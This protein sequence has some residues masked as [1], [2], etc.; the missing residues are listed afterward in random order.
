MRA[1]IPVLT[2]FPSFV[3]AGQSPIPQP[4]SASEV[5]RSNEIPAL[6]TIR[7]SGAQ[8]TDLGTVHGMRTVFARAGQRFQVFYVTAD[9]EAVIGGVMWNGAGDNI[10]REQVEA[11]DDVI[12]TVDAISTNQSTK[13]PYNQPWVKA[14]EA[15]TY[16]L[17]GNTGA[18]RL[19]MFFDPQCSFSIRAM[20]Q[21][22]PYVDQGRVQL[23]LVPVSILDHEDG[24]LSTKAALSLLSQPADQ[25]AA[26]WSAGRVDAP[27][28]DASTKLSRNMQAA[29]QI[30]LR[31]TPTF[32][33]R[34]AD[35]SEGRL[36]GVP[37]DF[38]TL[39]ARVGS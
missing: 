35:G 29:E 17:I 36:D 5:Q 16:G 21:L 25:M 26:S 19:W 13:Q 18:P 11:I 9:G 2:L 38:G 12:P 32:L 27:A 4:D 31:G 28:S 22:K 14:A 34:N 6:R 33:W 24:G 37:D 20:Q 1:I 30:H 23:A 8:L 10:T 15:T 3:L 7:A 39:I